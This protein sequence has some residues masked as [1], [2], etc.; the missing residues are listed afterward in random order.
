MEL[1]IYGKDQYFASVFQ[2][3]RQRAAARSRWTE[4][5]RELEWS[6]ELFRFAKSL[7]WSRNPVAHPQIERETVEKNI[8]EENV[9][10]LDKDKFE[11]L[12]KIY[13]RYRSD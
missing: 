8:I 4:L 3:R 10:G 13:K 1:A 7:R 9:L 5:K 11:K 6:P 12:W 2:T